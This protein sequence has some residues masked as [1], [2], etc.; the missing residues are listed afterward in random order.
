MSG[1]MGCYGVRHGINGTRRVGTK[2]QDTWARQRFRS[3]LRVVCALSSSKIGYDW[4]SF[5]LDPYKYHNTSWLALVNLA[6]WAL[7]LNMYMLYLLEPSGLLLWLT[8]I[9]CSSVYPLMPPTTLGAH[10]G[11]ATAKS[12]SPFRQL[13]SLPPWTTRPSNHLPALSFLLFWAGGYSCVA[14]ALVFFRRDPKGRKNLVQ[15]ALQAG[16]TGLKL[17]GGLL[18]PVKMIRSFYQ[19]PILALVATTLCYVKNHNLTCYQVLEVQNG[20]RSPAMRSLF[21][22]SRPEVHRIFDCTRLLKP[23]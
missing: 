3:W 5:T 1:L 13:P 15:L 17:R 19:W 8:A 16:Q 2:G 9:I 12:T 6:Y 14:S 23:S 21:G 22:T 18:A 7:W 4:W 20:W 10:T 11:Q